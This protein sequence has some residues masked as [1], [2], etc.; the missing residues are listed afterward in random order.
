M[1]WL[2]V[3]WDSNRWL[4]SKIVYEWIGDDVSSSSSDCIDGEQLN[5]CS[6]CW[7]VSSSSAFVCCNDELV[8][9][10]V[11][12]VDETD[13]DRRWFIIEFV[14][15]KALGFVG[16]KRWNKSSVCCWW[17]A[18]ATAAAAALLINWVGFDDDDVDDWI[19]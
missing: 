6:S 3:Q 1:K 7:M 5:G 14:P 15:C 19:G 8:V 13:D 17:N 4:Y 18:A 10:V 2:S 16:N 11:V 12:C 9:D